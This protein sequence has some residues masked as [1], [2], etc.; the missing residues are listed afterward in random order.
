[1]NP[2]VIYLALVAIAVIVSLTAM[3]MARPMARACPSC[4]SD[5]RLDA[6]ACAACGYAFG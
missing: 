4:D 5:V 6:R 3:A 1:M 2:L